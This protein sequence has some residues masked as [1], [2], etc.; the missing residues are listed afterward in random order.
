MPNVRYDGWRALRVGGIISLVLAM[1]ALLF[2]HPTSPLFL[3]LRPSGWMA[4]LPPWAMVLASLLLGMGAGSQ[5]VLFLANRHRWRAVFWPNVGRVV[6]GFLLA[7]L[8]PFTHFSGLPVTFLLGV[9]MYGAHTLGANLHSSLDATVL[10]PLLI[11]FPLGYFFSSLIIS[12]VRSRKVRVALFGQFWLATYGAVLLVFG[13][14]A[15]RL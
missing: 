3:D 1:L 15:F 8:C 14:S 10:L 12:G 5:L 7:V 9:G 11:A 4:P 2:D 13:Y 6:C